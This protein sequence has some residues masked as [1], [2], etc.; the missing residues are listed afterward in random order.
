MEILA[1][2]HLYPVL[3]KGQSVW[4]SGVSAALLLFIPGIP[5]VR[6]GDLRSHSLPFHCSPTWGFLPCPFPVC[7]CSSLGSVQLEFEPRCFGFPSCGERQRFCSSAS[8]LWKRP[9][10][11]YPLLLLA[12]SL[13]TLCLQAVTGELLNTACHVQKGKPFHPEEQHPFAHNL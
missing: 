9:Y 4:N 10:R 13:F 1:L 7:R 12:Q 11:N 6:C 2:Q 3:W 8:E 5:P